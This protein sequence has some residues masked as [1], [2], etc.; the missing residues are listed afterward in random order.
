M[1]ED[2]LFHLRH[3]TRLPRYGDILRVLVKFG[4]EDIV[5]RT[6]FRKL[7]GDKM[8][9]GKKDKPGEEI[10]TMT[11]P[12]RLRVAFQ[13]L[14]PTFVKI[15]QLLAARS[16]IMPEEY[17][18]ELARLHDDAAPFAYEKVE[19]ILRQELGKPLEELFR[20]FEEKPLAAASIAQVHE[21]ITLDG[22]RVVVKVQR[23][24]VERIIKDDLDILVHATS[25]LERQW[26]SLQVQHPS[27][28]AEE[29]APTLHKE[30]NFRIE[31]GHIEQFAH[32]FRDDP[33]IYVPG[34]YHDLT[35]RKVLTMDYV[36]GVKVA[37]L[38]TLGEDAYSKKEVAQRL[39]NL[40]L[41][42]VLVH[43]FF[44]A[45]PHPGNLF[46]MEDN[47]ICYIDFGMMGRMDRKSR[48]AFANLLWAIARRDEIR[49]T[50]AILNLT[51]H[52]RDPDRRSLEIDVADF[53][54]RHFYRPASQMEFG[55][56]LQNLLS[57]SSRHKLWIPTEVYLMLKAFSTMEDVV[58][59]MNPDFDLVEAA[60]P[61]V[62]QARMQRFQ[63]IRMTEEIYDTGSDFM[64]LAKA[65]PSEIRTI[66]RLIRRGKLEV[67]LE[68]D[69]LEPLLEQLV[70][71]ANR[72]AY[73]LTLAAIVVASSII[74]HSNTEPKWHNLPLLGDW[75]PFMGN[76]PVIGLLGYLI[77][78][79]MAFRLL[80][81]ISQRGKL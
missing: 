38:D 42:Q 17:R 62:V 35:T 51:E 40:V 12:E 31:A 8:M 41:E 11:P 48:E 1:A 20:G 33:T 16:D 65:M 67:G 9:P 49:A 39:A 3:V 54:S 34:V 25:F 6:G 63:P 44:H 27:R 79:Y 30:L 5:E 73:A 56:M 15:G 45:D 60:T 71:S 55:A 43:G 22:K 78:I 53:I 28:L 21:A 36:D 14:G 29:L 68:L 81:A 66:L 37:R 52:D 2:S 58:R 50:D 7:L 4:F 76:A 26:Q 75:F 74:I 32:L 10:H 69:T 77:A 46:I 72:L 24:G 57:N 23:P 59:R 47:V 80:R 64:D 19:K 13:E 18:K 70:Q 61:H